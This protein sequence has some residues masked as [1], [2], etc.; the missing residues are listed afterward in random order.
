VAIVSVLLS[1]IGKKISTIVQ[2]IFGWSVTALFGRLPKKKQLAVTFALV[3]SI[4]WPIFV[5]GL[6]LPGVAGWLLAFLPLRD[7]ASETTLRVIWATLA[8]LAPPMVGLLTHWAAPAT[9][10]SAWKAALHGYPLAL[11]YAVA[12]VVTVLTVPV[13]KVATILKGW[14]DVHVYVQ[15]REGRYDDVVR[16]LCE[17][18]VRAGLLPTVEDAPPRMT[19]ATSALRT[20]A[21]GMVTP[22]VAEQLKIVRADGIE[23]YPYPSDLL[24]RGRETSVAKVRAMMSRTELDADAYLVASVAGQRLQDELGRLTTVLRE[25][26]AAGETVG[27]MATSRLVAIWREMTEAMLPFEEWVLLESI[28]RRVERRIFERHGG[29]TALPLDRQEDGLARI[30]AQ[31]N[32]TTTTHRGTMTE[33]KMPENIPPPERLPLEEASTADLVREALDEAKELVKIEVALAKDEAKKEL[34]QA[35]HAAIGFG[36][37][38]ALALVVLSLLAVSIVLALGGTAVAALGVAA[39]FL[40]LGGVAGYVAW[41]MLPKKPLDHTVARVKRDVNQLKE[42]IA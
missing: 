15:P 19:F 2:A 34:Q 5:V 22:I 27:R 30:A 37:A 20:L 28:A 7:W 10:T 23:L 32:G 36:V 41:S 8:V 3:L 1:F 24:V 11:G 26:E 40:V 4:A 29:M 16:A 14:T 18:V 13:V 12:F 6:L 38:L 25:H 21:R 33:E 42:H 35:K 39:V 17:A 31:A 9:R